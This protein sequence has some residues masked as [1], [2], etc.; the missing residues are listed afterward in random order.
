[1][2][3]LSVLLPLVGSAANSTLSIEPFNIKAGETQTMLIDLNNPSQQVTLVELYMQLPEGLSLAAGD[4][5]YDIAGRTTWKKHSL[6][7]ARQDGL[8]HLMLASATNEL[9]SGTSGAL[10]SIRLTAASTFNG[11]TIILKDQLMASPDMTESRPADY[12]YKV[13]PPAVSD[14]VAIAAKSYTRQYGE[15]NPEFGY[16]VTSGAITSG[17]PVISCGATKDSPVGTY[18]ITIEKGTVSNGIVS[19]VS[20][21]LTITPAPLTI[22]AGYYTKQEGEAN[23][24]FSPSFSG[25]KNGE[26]S[27]VLTKQPVVSCTANASSAAGTYPVT[28]S[29]A[30][31][32]NYSITYQNGT[33]TVTAKSQPSLKDGDLFADFTP[34]GVEM[35]FKVIS[36]KDKTCQVGEGAYGKTAID[37]DTQGKLTIPETAK[38][39]RVIKVGEYALGDCTKIEELVYANTITHIGSYSCISFG[40]ELQTIV[41]PNNDG[42]TIGEA[43][44]QNCYK[45]TQLTLPK[46]FMEFTG[47]PFYNCPNIKEFI[48]HSDNPFYKSVDGILWTK[49][50]KT[51]MMYPAGKEGTEYQVPDGV[52]AL[53]TGAFERSNL[54]TVRIPESVK[55]IGASVFEYCY[56][57]ENITLPSNITEIP[58][59][60]F[61]YC[62][63]L[64]HID[65]PQAVTTIGIYAF[66]QTALKDVVLPEGMTSIGSKA[67]C[68]N[69]MTDIYSYNPTP[70]KIAATSFE[71]YDSGSSEYLFTNATLHV[72]LGTKSLYQQTDG[73]KNF[74]NI[75][76]MG[77]GPSGKKGDLNGDGEVNST[78]LV[79][80]VNMIM[81]NTEK[82]DIADLNAD[83]LVNSTDLV[84]LVNIIMGE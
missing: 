70:F 60:A 51:L 68:S 34:E 77:D 75:V 44:Y 5:S 63:Q 53:W 17:K 36:A 21:T 32:Q 33:L 50:G 31:A 6:Y 20:G 79:I 84:I 38:G 56:S 41:L 16:D 74:Q 2:F 52:E 11:G 15:D 26:T 67:F 71:L 78:D 29:G 8:V 65:I 42:F 4:D 62:R 39:F 10:I 1:M 30:E 3:I 82:K 27:A 47:Y 57:L 80:M 45:L 46:G 81:G 73:W 59:Y 14:P 9:V 49:D 37:K 35:T 22:S 54:V 72:P 58:K 28:V 55:T 61:S 19:T 76:E 23:P 18:E 24:T 13:E 83:G 43:V 69:D 12:S 48:V 40:S 66:F 25:F 7:M 64:K